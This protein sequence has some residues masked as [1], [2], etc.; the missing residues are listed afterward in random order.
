MGLKRNWWLMAM[1][2]GIFVNRPFH[3]NVKC[4]LFSVVCMLLLRPENPL[5]YPV[6]FVCAYVSM[7]WYDYM[8]NCDTIL[9]SG[10][11]IGPN[12]LDA[13]FKPQRRYQNPE[14]VQNQENEY[15]KR[16]NI[17]HVVIGF[18]LSWVGYQGLATNSNFFPLIGSLGA[19]AT[20]YHLF[21]LFVPRQT[22]D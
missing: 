16:V 22:T 13:I 5:L 1:A 12:T 4:L 14:L 11:S 3:L 21:R 9:F 19:I 15:L 7:A 20:G 6:I 2:G 10:S 8:Y 18:I 17:F